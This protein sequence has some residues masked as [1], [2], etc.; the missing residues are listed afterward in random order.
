MF[1]QLAPQSKIWIY[2]ADRPFTAADKVVIAEAMKMFLP[3]WAAHGNSLFGDYSL[4]H[5]RFLILAVDETQAGASG[6]SIDT[7]VRFIKDLG[8]KLNI[9]F[10]NRLNMIIEEDGKLTTVHVS[11][12]KEH[13]NAFVFNPM[14]TNLADLRE[15]WKVRVEESPFV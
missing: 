14:I 2:T 12:L 6:C 8:A 9:D 5:D 7:S 13:P 11:E 3:Q 1:E 15:N 10:F 4:E